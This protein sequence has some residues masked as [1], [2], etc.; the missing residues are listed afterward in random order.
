MNSSSTPAAV[1][2]SRCASGFWSRVLTLPYPIDAV[3]GL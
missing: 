3:A 2:W 1:S